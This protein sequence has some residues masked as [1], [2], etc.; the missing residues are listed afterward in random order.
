MLV[1]LLANAPDFF[2]YIFPSTRSSIIRI[3]RNGR[4][5]WTRLGGTLYIIF[6][7][8][9]F[10][11]FRPLSPS[12]TSIASAN[13]C[14]TQTDHTLLKTNRSHRPPTSAL[15]HFLLSGEKLGAAE[16]GGWSNTRQKEKEKTIKQKRW[17]RWGRIKQ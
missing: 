1:P 14:M 6:P 15:A 5:V 3:I 7:F 8:K 4:G 11:R 13:H 2:M 16:G 9:I 17:W 10:E 12:V